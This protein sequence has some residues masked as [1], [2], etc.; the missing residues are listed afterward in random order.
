MKICY[1]CF[2]EM[3]D[4]ASHCSFCGHSLNNVN[5]KKYP[6]ALL[7]GSILHGEYIIGRVLGQGGFGITY[8][9]QNYSTKELVAIKEFFPSAIATR[10]GQCS[11]QAYNE[12]SSE[13]FFF[14]K[15]AFLQEATTLSKFSENPNI[16]RIR[17]FFE[18]NGTAYFVMEYVDGESLKSYV[19]KKGGT[20]PFEQAKQILDPVLDALEA[21][22]REGIVHRDISPDNIA[23]SSDGKVK[24]LDFGAARYSMGEKSRSLSVVL[25]HGYAP[26]EQYSRHGNQGPWTDVY[27]MAATFYNVL[28]G[29]M[30]P[31]SVDRIHQDTLV[32][33]SAMGIPVPAYAEAALAKALSVNAED[34]FQTMADF[35]KALSNPAGRGLANP[36]G[37]VLTIPGGGKGGEGTVRTGAPGGKKSLPD[38][39]VII[40]AVAGVIL[41]LILF[42]VFGSNHKSTGKIED[43]GVKKTTDS[44]DSND[45]G[46]NNTNGD[47]SSNGDNG[48]ADGSDDSGGSGDEGSGGD[49]NGTGSDGTGGDDNGTGSDGTGG[50]GTGSE[51]I[52]S[53]SGDDTIT[54]KYPG[55][56]TEKDAIAYVKALLDFICTG[57]YDTSSVKFADIDQITSDDFMNQVVDSIASSYG[58]QYNLTD[59]TKNV[60]KETMSTA[61]SKCK[62]TVT[63][64]KKKADDVFDVTISIEPLRLYDG[65]REKLNNYIL[66]LSESERSSMTQDELFNLTV[67]KTFAYVSEN[68]TSPRYDAAEDVVV[69]YYLMDTDK[70]IYG[71]N[72]EDGNKIGVKLFSMS[73]GDDGQDTGTSSVTDESS[74]DDMSSSNFY[75]QG[76]FALDGE[77]FYYSSESRLHKTTA[78]LGREGSVQIRDDA[79]FGSGYIN[80][81]GGHIYYPVNHKSAIFRC[82]LDGGNDVMVFDASA[83]PDFVLKNLC[84]H[85]GWFYFSNGKDLYRISRDRLDD[86]SAGPATLAERVADDFNYTEDVYPSICFV[87]GG[88]YYNGNGG[89]TRIDPDGSNKKLVSEKS[90][91]LSSDDTS[92]YSLYGTSEIIRN[93]TD[94]SDSSF[95]KLDSEDGWISRINYVDGWLYLVIKTDSVYELWKVN[96]ADS[97][98]KEFVGEITQAA[99]SLISFCTFENSDYGCFYILRSNDEGGL[100]SIDKFM[101]IK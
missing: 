9:A 41:L 23:L 44:G 84:L 2:H 73:M 96:T 25:K 69:T 68:L 42:S 38:K 76:Y 17:Q 91:E 70:H 82:D 14:G 64:A 49:D 97:S 87:G 95:F 60:I 47:D 56:A 93:D 18:E 81:S 80:L 10:S 45:N 78:K 51:K 59:E 35:K 4:S 26:Y 58:D 63:G 89:L 85:G 15:N 13:G 99:D 79:S 30:V 48:N 29:K 50:D 75:N 1:N 28:T 88:I 71:I 86:I 62:Y 55:K 72:E 43:S 33:P 94:G 40:G 11:V 39:K 67:Q 66:G 52:D 46:G 83:D 19:Q 54:G 7:P 98:K 20:L 8:I 6:Q 3:E 27:A 5:E 37:K 57:S 32:M 21:V 100:T 24:L 12:Q 34:R 74:P 53:G 92:I 90:G 77:T 31:D 16:V 36:A 61:L 101:K 22:H 65:V